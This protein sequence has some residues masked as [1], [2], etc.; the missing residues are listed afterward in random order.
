MHRLKLFLSGVATG[1]LAHLAAW[2]AWVSADIIVH[3]FGHVV[4]A[5]LIRLMEGKF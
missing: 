5:L 2:I 4:A 3:M 1:M